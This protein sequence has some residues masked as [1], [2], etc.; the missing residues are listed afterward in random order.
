MGIMVSRTPIK[1]SGSYTIY[2]FPKLKGNNN[3]CGST[4]DYWDEPEE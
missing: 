3:I 1:Q 4:C 2:G